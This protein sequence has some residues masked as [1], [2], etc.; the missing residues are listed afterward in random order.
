MSDRVATAVV[1][2]LVGAVVG[3]IVAL[4]LAPMSGKELQLRVRHEAETDWQK[5][6]A[7]Y[8]KSV[9]EVQKSFDGLKA[10]IASLTGRA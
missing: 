7:E 5:A 4:F 6:R 1:G 2:F 8:Y 10:Q 9:N 3:A